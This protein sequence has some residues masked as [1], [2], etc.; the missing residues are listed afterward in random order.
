MIVYNE[1]IT[2]D[3][4]IISFVE[5]ESGVSE[6]EA[7]AKNE[8]FKYKLFLYEEWEIDSHEVSHKYTL[9]F[10]CA[11]HTSVNPVF[12]DWYEEEIG[13]DNENGGLVNDLLKE[14]LKK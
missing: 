11:E 10:Q 14:I 3:E 2:K 4:L 1:L 7:I 8:D 13:G 6:Y 12:F 9:K 5:E